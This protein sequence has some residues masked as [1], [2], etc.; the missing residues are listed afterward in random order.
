MQ[1]AMNR[2]LFEKS[3]TMAVPKG[4]L[5][6]SEALTGPPKGEEFGIL[7]FQ[8]TPICTFCRGKCGFLVCSLLLLL[9]LIYNHNSGLK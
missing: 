2:H 1:R 4:C 6:S 8:A 7:L 5:D 3:D 9:Y